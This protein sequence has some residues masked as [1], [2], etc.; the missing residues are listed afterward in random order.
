[1]STFQIIDENGKK[2]G[3]VEGHNMG[4]CSGPHTLPDGR[5]SREFDILPE[6]GGD[7]VVTNI[8]ME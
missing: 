6:N 7:C 2:V 5:L 3:E 8:V 4:P 1:M